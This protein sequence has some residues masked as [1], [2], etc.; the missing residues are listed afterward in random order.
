MMVGVTVSGAH[1]RVHR[2]GPLILVLVWWLSSGL[3]LQ[4]VD[5]VYSG[6]PR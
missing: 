1:H 5:P 6:G 2:V 4:H 3:F